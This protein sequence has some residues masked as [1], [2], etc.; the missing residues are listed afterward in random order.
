[1]LQTSIIALSRGS[2]VFMARRRPEMTFLGGHWGFVGGRVA[3]DDHSHSDPFLACA[4]RETFEETGVVADAE[5]LRLIGDWRNPDWAPFRYH[6]RFYELQLGAEAEPEINHE[7]DDSCWIR[8]ADALTMWARGEWLLSDPIR[9]VLEHLDGAEN[10]WPQ[11]SAGT[12]FSDNQIFPGVWL[13]SV[14]SKTIPAGMHTPGL[15]HEPMA[16]GLRTNTIVLEGDSLFVIDPGSDSPDDHQRLNAFIRSTGKA[17]EAVILTHHHPDHVQ[18][19]EALRQEFPAEVWAHT[20]TLDELGLQG[21]AL[22]NLEFT[23]GG[24]RWAI[25][26]TPGHAQGH[27]ILHSPTL[28]TIICGDMMASVG[29]ILISPQDGNMADYLQSLESMKGLSPKTIIPSHGWPFP[30]AQ[31]RIQ[32]YIDHR[33]RRE[34]KIVNAMNSTPQSLDELLAVAYADTPRSVWPLARLSLEAHLDFLVEKRV[35]KVENGFFV[36]ALADA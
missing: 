29:T 11:F 5:A 22:E 14:R 10:A 16:L 34:Q 21:R 6:S 7:F 12:H 30:D 9:A 1:M 17:V 19:L 36:L 2:L 8:P 24:N 28:N 3:D 32:H 33:L 23:V 20:H 27:L 35:A 31:A 26:P 13:L 18:G 15:E 25:H 4:L